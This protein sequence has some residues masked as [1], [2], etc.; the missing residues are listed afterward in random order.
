MNT[1]DS[2]DPAW[3]ELAIFFE[4]DEG[5]FLELVLTGTVDDVRQAWQLLN[6]AGAVDRET[7]VWHIASQQK[8]LLR[9][10]PDPVGAVAAD[11]VG[12]VYLLLR[13]LKDE[14]VSLPD[15]GCQVMATC[16]S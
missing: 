8:I 15:L 10:V 12:T 9:E 4:R 13:G 14:A 1:H 2:F 3:Q 5:Y 7:A 11:E 16:S 6:V